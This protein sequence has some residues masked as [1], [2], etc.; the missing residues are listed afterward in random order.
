[1]KRKTAVK[2]NLENEGFPV[3]TINSTMTKA[4][5]AQI[6]LDFKNGQTRC[7]ISTDLLSR[8]IDIQQLSLVVNYDLPYS[9]KI[10]NYIHRIGRTG[11]AGASGKA[12]SFCDVEEQPYIKSIEKL[13]GLRIKEVKNHP[14]S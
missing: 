12:L 6:L 13:I 7:L 2:Q 4:Q 9:N 8:G 3:L 5:R 11:R 14:F 1:M 10:S